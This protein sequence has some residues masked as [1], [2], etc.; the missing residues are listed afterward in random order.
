VL[1]EQLIA[2]LAQLAPLSTAAVFFFITR[3]P[4]VE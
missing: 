1:D 2:A 4:S 3:K